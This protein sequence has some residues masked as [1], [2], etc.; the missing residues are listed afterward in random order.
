MHRALFLVG[1]LAL[2]ACSPP[3]A[4]VEEGASVVT[5]SA[6]VPYRLDAPSAVM[7]LARELREISG[8]AWLPSGRLAAVQDERGTIFEIDPA[9]GTILRAT[10]FHRAGDF[11]GVAWDGAA[12]WAIESGGT[13]HRLGEGTPVERLETGL[14]ARCDAEGLEWDGRR[15]LVACK[16]DPG[17]GLRGVRAVYAVDPA[18]GALSLAFTLDRRVVDGPDGSF[19]PSAIAAHPV[20][21]DLYLLSAARRSLAVVSP[22]GDLRHVAALPRERLSQPEGLAFAPDGTLY[23][24][25]EGHPSVLLRYDPIPPASI[26]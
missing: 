18:S 25:S 4:R 1:L 9:T 23:V 8:L 21:G 3:Q 11:E 13:L 16:E 26:P 7:R 24:A 19:K 12:L 2:C 14:G 22:D 10:P 17:G 5:P 20:T 15:L 6:S